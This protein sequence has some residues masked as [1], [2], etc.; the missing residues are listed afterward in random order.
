ML[1]ALSKSKKCPLGSLAG[2]F[3]TTENG[4]GIVH[5]GTYFWAVIRLVAKLQ[6]RNYR[7]CGFDEKIIQFLVDLQGDL[8]PKWKSCGKY[9]KERIL[10]TW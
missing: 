10:R 6:N 4:T 9:V 8:G 2:D 5:T 1:L 7:L 3:V